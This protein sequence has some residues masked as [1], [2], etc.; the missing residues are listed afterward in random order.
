M[1]YIYFNT[2]GTAGA[3]FGIFDV[4]AVI[5]IIAAAVLTVLFISEK[6]KVS[7]LSDRIDKLT[8]GKNGKSLEGELDGII[9]DN[10]IIL[11]QAKQNSE[12]IEEIFGRLKKVYQKMS[13]VKYDAYDQLGGEMSAVVVLLDDEDNGVLVNNVYSPEGGYTY[14]REIESGK[15]RHELGEEETKAL[16]KA[17]QK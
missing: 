13:V 6:K 14:T 17:L 7:E 16:K 12:D 11:K 9:E 4:L 3:A 8:S 2:I 10:R 1:Q 15:C 5:S